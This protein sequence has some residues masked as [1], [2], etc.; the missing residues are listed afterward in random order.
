MKEH[1]FEKLELTPVEEQF[2]GS[3]LFTFQPK[4]M[5]LKKRQISKFVRIVEKEGE[6]TNPKMSHF[7]EAVDTMGI[8]GFII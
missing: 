4:T 6:K 7:I 8:D 1:E 5:E 2:D 3:L